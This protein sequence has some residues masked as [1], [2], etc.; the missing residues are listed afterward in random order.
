MSGEAVFAATDNGLCLLKMY[1][2]T[3]FH[4]V[5]KLCIMYKFLKA[6]SE[7]GPGEKKYNPG[8]KCQGSK[9][10]IMDESINTISWNT[11]SQHY[12]RYCRF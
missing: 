12:K 3:V 5:M 8:R 2:D 7:W 6:E 11:N 10:A 9:Q 4:R 1:G